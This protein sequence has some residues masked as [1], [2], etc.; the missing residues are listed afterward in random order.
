M[1][2]Y[3]ATGVDSEDPLSVFSYRLDHPEPT[4]LA[5]NTTVLVRILCAGVNP[6]DLQYVNGQ[7][8]HAPAHP[9]PSFPA[10]MGVEGAGVVERVGSK[11]NKF[12]PGDHVLG[13][14]RRLDEGTFA[15]LASFEEDEL[16]LKPSA[17]SWQVAAATPV[18]GVTAL[19]ALLC[20]KALK[21]TYQKFVSAHSRSKPAACINRCAAARP[22]EPA[23]TDASSTVKS[24]LIL[25]ATGGVGSFAVLLAKHFFHIPLVLATCSAKNAQYAHQLGADVAIDYTNEDVEQNALQAVQQSAGTA[26]PT[27]ICPD[28]K[29]PARAAEQGQSSSPRKGGVKLDLI[30][31]NVG[32][33]EHMSMACRLLNQS[34][35]YVT[36]VPLA[37]PQDSSLSSVLSFF[38]NLGV[39]KLQHKVACSGCP[40]VA[41]NGCTPGG[42]KVQTLVDWLAAADDIIHSSSVQDCLLRITEHDLADA[43]TALAAVQSRHAVGKLVLRVREP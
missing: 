9:M 20:Y 28:I 2:A 15:E 39:K 43:G 42:D 24:V 13:L 18:A 14:H 8:E 25:G 29:G 35:M 32:G 19:S 31:D 40:A 22:V 34:G 26:A 7:Y 11:V 16:A 30:I 6:A 1:R 5:T 10:P 3:V 41:F 23:S 33:S 12:K 21:P 36:S 37:D 17:V 27:C 38:V 4:V